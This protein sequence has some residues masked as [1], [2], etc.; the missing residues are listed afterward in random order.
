MEE[1]NDDEIIDFIREHNSHVYLMG[2]YFPNPKLGISTGIK[3][4][5]FFKDST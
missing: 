5:P 2:G 1:K 3:Y 4:Q